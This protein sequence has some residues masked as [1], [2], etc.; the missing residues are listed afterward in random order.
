MDASSASV[1]SL[2]GG[3]GGT[4][5]SSL[6]FPLP[7][8]SPSP[9]SSGRFRKFRAATWDS[10][11]VGLGK[12]NLSPL[13][14]LSSDRSGFSEN[15]SVT[16]DDANDNAAGVGADSKKNSTNI[17]NRGVISEHDVYFE[18]S[19]YDSEL[20]AKLQKND[21]NNDR[22]DE[23]NDGRY[24]QFAGRIDLPPRLPMS[25]VEYKAG[26]VESK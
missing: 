10:A 4:H 3:G 23:E 1:P 20:S 25:T 18:E 13:T 12:L 8:P 17:C 11:G 16:N 9:T 21:D 22:N 5:P 15:N 26:M 7:P 19:S 2:G 6:S 24:D 14:R